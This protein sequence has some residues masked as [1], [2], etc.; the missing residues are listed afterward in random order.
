MSKFSVF[1][2]EL[3][4][5]YPPYLS[6]MIVNLMVF[7]MMIFSAYFFNGATFDTDPYWG[8]FSL[9]SQQHFATFM[10]MAIILCMGMMLSFVMV[11]KLFPDPIIPSMALAF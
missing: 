9:F 2:Q 6:M 8:V 4:N 5:H 11:S 10:Y 7:V 3:K 1:T